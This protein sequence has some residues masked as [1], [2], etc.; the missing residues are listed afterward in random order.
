MPSCYRQAPSSYLR[1]CSKGSY[2]FSHFYPAPSSLWISHFTLPRIRIST[3]T[4]LREY[5]GKS[6][7]DH[8]QYHS[9]SHNGS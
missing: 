3:S 4:P 1:I 8:N 2:L 7:D 6:I 9:H 5:L